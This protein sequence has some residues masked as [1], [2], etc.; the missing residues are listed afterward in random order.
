VLILTAFNLTNGLSRFLSGYFSNMMGRKQVLGAT[1]L[2]AGLA[3]FLF[4][5]L[6][7]HLI[8]AVLAAVI[9]F[10]FETLHSVSPPMVSDCFGIE[11][12]GSVFG[13][14][15][16]AFGFVSGA[17]GPWLS[18]FLLDITRENFSLVFFYLGVLLVP[19]AL[20]VLIAS[21]RTEYRF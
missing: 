16:T 5:Y 4:P 7:G 21:S 3:Y 14:V 20:L 6:T 15:F 18:G 1:L 12:F 17:L 19:S 8:W 2:L 9:G 11:N 13:M 10:S